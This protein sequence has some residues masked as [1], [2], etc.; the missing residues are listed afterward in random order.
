[1]GKQ[2]TKLSNKRDTGLLRSSFVVSFFT[3]V[4]RVAGLL[5]DVVFARLIGADALADVFFVAFK[6][7]NFFRRIF[8]EGAFS[9]A[10]VPVLGEYRE[11]K[12][13]S[14][15]KNFISKVSGTF[16]FTLAFFGLFFI[17]AVPFFS[18][19][20]A[21]TWYLNDPEKFDALKEM[22]QITFPYLI[23]IS[24]TG[25]V[26]AVLQSYDRFAVPAATPIILNITLILAAIFLAPMLEYP[27]F[28]LAWGV[29]I[30]GIVQFCFQL[31]FIYRIG[32][33]TP[34]SIDW[35]DPGVTKILTLMA[36]AIF[37]VSVSQINLL[38]D[39]IL[40]TFLPTGSVSWLY[41]SDRIT[42]LPLGIFAIAIAV[43]ILP[44]LSRM[45]AAKSIENFSETLDWGI[46]MIFYIALPSTI[47]ILILSEPI[48]V[49]LFFYGDVMT[50]MDMKM[51]SFS[52]SAY[53]LGLTGFMLIKV[54][55]PGF[56]ARQDMITPVRVGIIA[57]IANMVFNLALVIPL[58]FF[59][60]LGH[61]GLALATSISSFLN[62]GLLLY[63]S[64]KKGFYIPL[65]GW[66]RFFLRISVSLLIMV[67]VLGWI[68]ESLGLNNREFWL[69]SDFWNRGSRLIVVCVV[70]MCVYILSLFFFGV[71]K[72]DFIAPTKGVSSD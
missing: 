27:V 69:N 49:A 42:E 56:F 40:A 54:L 11:G 33:L 22:L 12:S 64:L 8:A 65:P 61:V 46:K 15:V 59:F 57:M 71:R 55:A 44:N 7:P 36:P 63:Y 51:A 38:L 67:F 19:L 21:P 24:M 47:A 18:A 53:A 30:A 4:S 66:A 50:A 41:Y 34:P 58:F 32:L 23:F 28:A 14:A 45:H 35:K 52:L 13:K 37:G 29:L 25:L 2:K 9:Q 31:P 1:M 10:F 72:A 20:F 70:G 62:A 60:N 3:G 43:V 68:S 16:G 26:G 5:R 17:L 39:T 48:L 6:I